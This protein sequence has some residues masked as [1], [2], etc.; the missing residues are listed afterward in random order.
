VIY[1]ESTLSH[2]LLDITIEKLVATIPTN[3]QKNRSRLKVMP[4]E[5]GI[6]LLQEYDSRRIM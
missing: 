3:A 1:I 4:L 6:V 5:R 2:H